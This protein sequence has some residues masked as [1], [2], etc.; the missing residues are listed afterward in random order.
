MSKS[1]IYT[2]NNTVNAVALNGTIPLGTTN[3]RFGR[4]I[5]Q[6]GNGIILSGEGYYKVSASISLAPTVVGNV[7]VGL[8]QDNVLVGGATATSSV[9]TA[10]NF[11]NLNIESLIRL[12]CCDDTST[13]TLVLS[14]ANATVSNVAVVVE[15]L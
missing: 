3:R 5:V 12:R 1:A 10:N 4:N 15:K 11:T 7:S 2:V 14:G 13:L 6:S 8:Y 9:S